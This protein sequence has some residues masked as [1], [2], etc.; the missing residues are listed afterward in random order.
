MGLEI[1]ADTVNWEHTVCQHSRL[2]SVTW[3]ETALQ[4]LLCIGHSKLRT[5][6]HGLFIFL[7]ILVWLSYC[8]NQPQPTTSTQPSSLY[9]GRCFISSQVC[10]HQSV[11]QAGSISVLCAPF[12]QRFTLQPKLLIREGS[13][14][15]VSPEISVTQSGRGFFNKQVDIV[16]GFHSYWINLML[17]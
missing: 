14:L 1:R 7:K 17:K 11:L 16:I 10:L 6:K 15:F 12:W 4:F 5:P 9:L 8:L 2:G 3:E 13:N